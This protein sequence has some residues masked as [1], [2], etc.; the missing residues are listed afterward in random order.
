LLE[1]MHLFWHAMLLKL[2]GSKC[3]VN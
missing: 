3:L 1:S 2:A